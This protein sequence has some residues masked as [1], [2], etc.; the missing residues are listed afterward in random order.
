MH[1]AAERFPIRGMDH[2][3]DPSE[4]HVLRRRAPAATVAADRSAKRFVSAT[5]DKLAAWHLKAARLR[6]QLSA[7]RDIQQAKAE[8][9]ELA[10]L[11]VAARIE[12]E[13]VL[14]EADVVVARHSLV[15]DVARSL[16]VLRDD[17]DE[18]ALS[19]SGPISHA[20]F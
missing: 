7:G 16:K 13:A 18:M 10:A 6:A 17:L 2:A 12:F 8:A 1:L 11:L 3:Q 20:A 14:E 9:A 19:V 15:R 5:Q 4:L